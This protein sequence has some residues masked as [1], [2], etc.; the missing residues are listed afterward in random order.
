QPRQGIVDGIERSDRG[1]AE[2]GAALLEDAP[3][4]G[5]DEREDH[6]PGVL[7]DLLEDALEMRL[8]AHHRP[9]MADRLDVVI[10]GERGLGDVLQRLA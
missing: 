9:E 7:R 3:V 5:V 6:Q 10:L 8:G 1:Q 4:G 2:R